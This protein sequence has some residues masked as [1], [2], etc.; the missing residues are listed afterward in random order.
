MLNV[1]WPEIL[2]LGLIGFLVLGPERLPKYA[3]DAARLIRQLRR[4]ATDASAD[5]RAD[6]GP[7]MAD[8]HLTDLANPRR[9][10]ARYLLEA[11]EESELGDRDGGD[12]DGDLDADRRG[13]RALRRP[14]GSTLPVGETPPFDSDAT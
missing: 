2:M 11:G 4:M 1:G 8:L 13:G 7:E 6:L 3:A 10:V 12:L 9:M 14:S 5:L